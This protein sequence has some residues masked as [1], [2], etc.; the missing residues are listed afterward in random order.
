MIDTDSDATGHVD[1][2]S[3]YSSAALRPVTGYAARSE[4][5]A[6]MRERLHDTVRQRG[7]SSKILVVCGLG[8]AGKSQLTLSYIESYRDDY[9]AVFWIDAGA[10]IRLEAD[11]KQIRNQLHS[12]KRADIDLDTC[13]AEV[14]QWCHH[15]QGRWLF[16][17][18]SADDIDDPHSAAY[19]DLRRI[20]VDTLSAD[21][22][23]TT[24]NPSAQDMTDLEAIQVAELTPA[25]AR[26]LFLKRS[27]LPSPSENVYEEVDAIAEELGFFALAINLAAA[28]VAET[29]RL[30]RHPGGYPDEYRRRR[31]KLLDRKPKAHVDQY[32]ASV[33]T[34]WETSY[35]SMFDRCPEA[36]DLLMFLAFLSPDDLFLEL[37]QADN[38]MVRDD[39]ATWLLA[40]SSA[41]VQEVLD[42]SLEVLR[43]YSLLLWTDD[44]SSCTMHMHK[45]V[46]AWSFERSDIT[47]K[48]KSCKTAL[49]LLSSFACINAEGPDR[50]ARLV[51]H[52]MVC[53]AR[54][55]EV[56][57][58]SDDDKANIV[59][60]MRCLAIFLS[61][62]G[63]RDWGYDLYSFV[64]EHY[65]RRRLSDQNAYHASVVDL[66]RAMLKMGR[67]K[68]VV[69]L[70]QPALSQYRES[71]ASDRRSGLG[72]RI[73]QTLG[74]ALSQVGRNAEAESMFRQA[75]GEG[76][77]LD[78]N[79]MTMCFLAV[80]LSDMERNKE[81]EEL[82]EQVF[83]GMKKLHGPEAPATLH[84]LLDY[85]EVMKH[86]E[87][88]EKSIALFRQALRGFEADVGPH[89]LP[90]LFCI[91]EC[92]STYRLLGDLN[93]AQKLLQQ[94]LSG[95]EK[96][97]GMRHPNTLNCAFDLAECLR[98]QRLYYE[99]LALY[100]KTWDSYEAAYGTVHPG[101]IRCFARLTGLRSFLQERAA[102]HEAL[103]QANTRFDEC[104][105]AGQHLRRPA[106]VRG[107]AFTHS[108]GSPDSTSTMD[109]GS[110]QQE[111]SDD[112]EGNE[113]ETVSD[114]RWDVAEVYGRTWVTPSDCE[115]LD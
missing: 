40:E 113:W 2:T 80:A 81:A 48:A 46:N 34:T 29:P 3:H 76:E 5:Q 25:E 57:A 11:Y 114:S 23:I 69:E 64:H 15:K 86:S 62:S 100:Q 111:E 22:I 32:G 85:A 27:K 98:D 30:R 39:Y 10:R 72:A 60:G 110:F 47:S 77:T 55:C 63:E 109:R 94:A 66:G 58:E 28:Y 16:V 51:S 92:G 82:S 104:L 95:L 38:H 107:R 59:D 18:D 78:E 108:G 50:S 31:R 96:T 87:Q 101:I 83:E 37:F 26:D 36:C 68:E 70:L 89:V 67:G 9:T 97:L 7:R 35:A 61:N 84:A 49:E 19:I 112:S 12:S 53:F 115:A 54:A 88:Y 52:I 90:V 1:Y 45:L 44:Q 79:L 8:G 20:V 24:R 56:Y 17:Y 103:K 13:V 14:K 33:L 41:S 102:L 105:Q 73:L 91:A 74:L 71:C 93:E 65:R 106:F 42:S 21:V 43:S 4:L 75:L 6:Q 99:A